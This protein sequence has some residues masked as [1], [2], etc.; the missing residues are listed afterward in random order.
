[1]LGTL[2]KKLT[3]TNAS[4]AKKASNI[5]FSLSITDVL[6]VINAIS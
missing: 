4:N 3:T 6:N 5:I 2:K 1:M